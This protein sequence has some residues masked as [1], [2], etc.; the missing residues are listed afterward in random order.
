VRVFEP[1]DELGF[2]VKP[3]NEVGLIGILS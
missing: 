2:G 3:A 1:G